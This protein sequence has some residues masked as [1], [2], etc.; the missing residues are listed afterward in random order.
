[1]KGDGIDFSLFYCGWNRG[2]ALKFVVRR[3]FGLLSLMLLI[4]DLTATNYKVYMIALDYK[5]VVML[6]NCVPFWTFMATVEKLKP[7]GENLAKKNSKKKFM[8]IINL[9]CVGKLAYKHLIF[10][11]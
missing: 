11:L 3:E 2:P 5:K 10:C 6:L 1:M 7:K 9:H 8:C 4:S